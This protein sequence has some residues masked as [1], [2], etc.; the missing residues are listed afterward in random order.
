MQRL[1]DLADIPARGL[2][3]A[4]RDGPFED[5]GILIRL[6]DGIVRAYKNECRHLAMR[7]DDREPRQLW[8]AEGVSLMC[9]SHGARY[10]PSDGLCIAGPCRGSHLKSLPVEVR[11]G[12][13]WLDTSKLGGF[14]NVE[15]PQPE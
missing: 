1:A 7:L 4:Y 8:D 9:N 13:V 5:E 12:A 11:D 6:A 10:R 3:F 14:F 2:V 15:N